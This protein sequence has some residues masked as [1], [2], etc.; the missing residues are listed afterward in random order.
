M[1]TARVVS[2]P[3]YEVLLGN[4]LLDQ[5]GTVAAPVV[6]AHRYVVITDSTVAALYAD[7]VLAS[8]APTRTDLLT[9][10]PGEH[11]KTRQRWGWLTDRLLELECGRDTVI[12]ALGGGVVGD[13]AGFTAATFLRGVPV[14]QLPTTLLAMVDASVGGKTAVDVPAGKNLVG[15]FHPPALVVADPTVLDTL[16]D[17]D[18]RAGLAEVIKHGVIADADYLA[19]TVAAMPTLIDAAGGSSEVM[20][21]TVLRSVQIKAAVVAEDER[22]AG[23]RR[24]LNFGHTLGHAM[25]SLSGYSLLHGEAVAIGMVLESR[26]AE[27]LGVA[28]SGTADAVV[29]A[30][31][32]AGLPVLPPPG[33]SRDVEQIVAATRVDKK[34][35]GGVVEYAL[36]VS[37][38]QMAGAD[39]GWGTT[40]DEATVSRFLVAEFA[41]AN[42]AAAAAG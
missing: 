18:R 5:L 22:E 36:P 9:I 39:R 27:W 40:V 4:G 6:R 11:E 16:P 8:L 35:R 7:R 38:G 32:R 2:L 30:V 20:L 26:L 25:E 3:G 29:H 12:V 21:E 15:A 19:R 33:D 23:R 31:T 17:A 41:A 24:I 13:L 42:E 28:R 14:I 10:P 34:A 37:V 1:V